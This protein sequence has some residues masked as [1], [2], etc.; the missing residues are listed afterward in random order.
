MELDG[1]GLTF[2]LGSALAWSGL[3]ATRKAMA[4][5]MT[6]TA[7]VVVLTLGQAPLFLS[8]WAVAGGGFQGA[9]YLVPGLPCLA[10][11]V[12]ANVGFVRAVQVSPLSLTVPLL[13]LTPVFTALV[14]LLVLS[15]VPTWT[16]AGGIALVTAGALLLHAG[17]HPGGGLLGALRAFSAE[18]G[19]VIMAGVALLW[20]LTVSL[21]KMAL[22]R[23]ALPA[24]A[25][26]QTGGVGVVL[27]A[28]LI[29]RRRIG[30]VRAVRGAR[31][32]FLWAV[33]FATAAIGLQLLAI[34]SLFVALVES[35]KRA[36]G[37]AMSVVVGRV[38]F[39]ERVDG[40]KWAAIALM[41][42]GAYLAR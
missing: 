26:V 23:A 40:F 41:A 37:M 8:W 42:A 6:P 34:Q 30:E 35:L 25:L 22:E 28:W 12:L 15:E 18:R 5:V 9:S 16:Q 14:G 21:D 4:R 29:C 20:S 7:S 31:A 32:P 24:H 10:L 33:A 3:D 13:S 11:N 17:R 19:S 39:D 27:A 1:S 36:V 38:A 2:A